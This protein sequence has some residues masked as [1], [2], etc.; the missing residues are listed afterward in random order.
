MSPLTPSLFSGSLT[1]SCK[2]VGKGI[3]HSCDEAALGQGAVQYLGCGQL[4]FLCGCG[5]LT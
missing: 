4:A 3:G 1:K 2:G 5:A